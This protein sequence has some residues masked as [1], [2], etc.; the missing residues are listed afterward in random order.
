MTRSRLRDLP[1]RAWR[2]VR[3]DLREDPSLPYVLLLAVVL[4]GFWIHHRVPNF[5]T[6][7]EKSRILDVL[8]AY[9]RV[10]DEPT[11][12]SLREGVAWSRVPFGATFHLYAVVLLP[13]VLAAWLLGDLGSIAGLGFPSDEFGFYAAWQSV[14]E[15]I[16]T[17]SILLVRLAN[18]AFAVAC[19]YLTYRI[20]TTAH[21]RIAGNLSALLLT[22]T[23]GFLTIAHEGGEDMPALFFVL[24]ALYLGLRYVRTDDRT[25]FVLAGAAGG[26]AIAFKLT[27]APVV[28]VVGAA[29]LLRARYVADSGGSD[30][31]DDSGGDDSGDSG[32]S[33]GDWR[34]VLW[35]PRL[36]VGGA[37]AGAGC[38]LLGFPTALV[39]EIGL[40]VDRIAVGSTARA[41][42]TTGPDAPIWWWF[43]RGYLSGLS[44]PLF[45]GGL[46]GVLASVA[47]LRTR[48]EGVDATAL[49]LAALVGYL[50]LFS[51]WHDFRV[52]HLLPTFPLIALLLGERLHALRE[53]RPSIARPLIAVLL[54]TSGAYAGVGVAG[55]ADM[56]RDNA[57]DW[58]VAEAGANDTVETYRVDFQ[59]TA[60]PYGMRVNHVGLSEEEAVH[61]P[62]YIQL[63]YRDL[64]FLSEGTYYRNDGHTGAYVEDLLGGETNYAIAAEFGPR[65][66]GFIPDRATPGSATDLLRYGVVP[67]TDQYA[68]EQE[69]RANQYTLILERTGECESTRNPPL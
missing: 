66:P 40:V 62:A 49:V 67:Q 23:F 52:H 3:S 20:G 33:D 60:V 38:I 45:L 41:T 35:R 16:W 61:C 47:S 18:V 37:L 56:P 55:Y 5:A 2:Q 7:D 14:P 42:H 53:A 13:V 31:G 51:G 25:L 65:P 58:L 69:L 34:E 30:G 15:W 28:L 59:D 63:G 29:Y 12:E 8:V 4:C 64:L 19:V 24:L 10:L 11:A 36:F 54:I 68:D 6:R 22:L 32:G 57:E 21:G 39:G 1:A 44:L 50:L 9:G 26:V 46:L 43:L 17:W 27:A 48:R